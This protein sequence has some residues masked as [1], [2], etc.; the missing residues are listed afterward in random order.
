MRREADFAVDWLA[1]YAVS[2][3]IPVWSKNSKP[4]DEIRDNAIARFPETDLKQVL[5][6]TGSGQ[7]VRNCLI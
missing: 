3:E 4:A 2:S 5:W 6:G 1:V 7:E